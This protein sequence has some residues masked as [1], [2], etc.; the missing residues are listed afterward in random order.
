MVRA[1]SK[2]E[3][4]NITHSA[5]HMSSKRSVE[6]F[7]GMKGRSTEED[8]AHT[9]SGFSGSSDEL[10][11]EEEKYGSEDEEDNIAQQVAEL[12]YNNAR[13]D[14]DINYDQYQFSVSQKYDLTTRNLTFKKFK[15]IFDEIF[16]DL[17]W[18]QRRTI[19]FQTTIVMIIF[20]FFLR[21]LIHYV[22]QYI[23]LS[24]IGVPVTQY[25]PYWQR[26][27]LTY[28]SWK[29][30]Q[31]CIFVATGAI[32]NTIVFLFL[33]GISWACTKWLKW[34]PKFWYKVICW[35][36]IYAVLDP[37]LTFFFDTISQAWDSDMYKF[38]NY[39]LKT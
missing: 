5:L 37:F 11:S 28:S 8:D 4:D 35:I 22:G 39:F 26:V 7:P 33:V 1:G 25:T 38:Y 10:S 3:L 29:F 36:G 27:E 13:D 16:L 14:E 34:F 12:V 24:I 6:R 19:F 18:R 21:I 15:Y 20:L 2:E 9:Q 32:S 30:W 31:D 17:R 23:I